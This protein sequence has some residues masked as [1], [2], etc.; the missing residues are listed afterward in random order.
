MGAYF[1]PVFITIIGRNL[2]GKMIRRLPF[3]HVQN[4]G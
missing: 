2:D 3:G 1:G 4:R